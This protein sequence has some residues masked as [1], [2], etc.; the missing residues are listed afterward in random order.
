LNEIDS[1]HYTDTT[2]DLGSLLSYLVEESLQYLN[3]KV[4]T[5][6]NWFPGMACQRLELKE[7]VKAFGVRFSTQLEQ[8]RIEFTVQQHEHATFEVM[9]ILGTEQRGWLS[10]SYDKGPQIP[11]LRNGWDSRGRIFG[12]I[13]KDAYAGRCEMLS[14]SMSLKAEHCICSDTICES[15]P[16]VCNSLESTK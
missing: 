6:N 13:R 12:I 8:L 2:T 10:K 3:S 9:V 16:T 14:R 5:T 11:Y 4:Y 15:M 1:E 7:I